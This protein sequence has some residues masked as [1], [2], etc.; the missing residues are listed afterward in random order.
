MKNIKAIKKNYNK[1]IFN[2]KSSNINRNKNINNK[3]INN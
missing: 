2:S 3:N 1:I